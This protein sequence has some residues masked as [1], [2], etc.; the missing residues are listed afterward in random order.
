MMLFHFVPRNVSSA[1]PVPLPL[2]ALVNCNGESSFTELILLSCSFA[3]G[4]PR[5]GNSVWF[6]K[7]FCRT[8]LSIKLNGIRTVLHRTKLSCCVLKIYNYFNLTQMKMLWAKL[9]CRHLFWMDI[10]FLTL[11]ME[12]LSWGLAAI[13]TCPNVFWG[14]VV[15]SRPPQLSQVQFFVLATN[16]AFKV[17][18]GEGKAR[19][20]VACRTARHSGHPEPWGGFETFLQVCF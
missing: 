14:L 15:Q 1:P 9:F 2:L 16:F 19:L 17:T 5:K 10:W 7:H 6:S 3:I 12:D 8:E 18:F 20:T 13:F 11:H 4:C